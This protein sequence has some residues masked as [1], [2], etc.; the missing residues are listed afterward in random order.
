MN[1]HLPQLEMEFRPYV[2]FSE[3]GTSREAAD[4]VR[5]SAAGMEAAVLELLR[6]V[7]P[8]GLTDAEIEQRTG[9]GPN[10]ARPRR[11]GLVLK[12]LVKDSG[13]RRATASGRQARVW[14]V[15]P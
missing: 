9:L 4:S 12:G 5:E 3:P 2:P 11:V 8:A 14:V 13:Q 6:S 10:T 1:K 7:Y 15:L